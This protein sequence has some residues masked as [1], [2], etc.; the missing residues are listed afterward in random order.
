MSK[1]IL[2]L[3]DSPT[4]PTGL[5][6]IAK[7]I[8]V[9]IHETMGE[10]FKVATFGLGG[11]LS[12]NFSFP[13]YP[14][15]IGKGFEAPELPAVWK[16]FAGDERGVVLTI[17]NPSWLWWMGTPEKLPAGALKDFMLNKPFDLW[18]YFPVDGDGPTGKLP[19]TVGDTIGGF[20][21]VLTY[22]KWAA[23][24]IEK[25]CPMLAPVEHLPHMIDTRHY[26]PRDKARSRAVFIERI[27]SVSGMPPLNPEVFLVGVVATN[28]ARKDWY[29]AFETCA[30][31][32]KFGVQVGMWIHTDA[33][34][35]HWNLEELARDFGMLERVI[36]TDH[37]LS[38]DDLALAYSACDVTLGIGSGEGWGYPLSESLACGTPVVHG[39]YA[40]GAE[41]V[42][43]AGLVEPMAFRGDG[44]YA[45][46]RPVYDAREWAAKAMNFG[47]GIVRSS[48]LSPYI[49]RDNAWPKWKEWLRAGIE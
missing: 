30:E 33:Y 19:A 36:F 8:A 44:F 20:D 7:D 24:V 2:I 11:P 42:P 26:H 28:S 45:I 16:D 32:R 47:Q 14:L 27:K 46:R 13:Q 23:G 48:L 49:Y 3:S 34:K 17:W 40:G 22:T 39:N 1:P 18:G 9:G 43:K 35:K 38:D 41:F 6:R 21:R 25:T 15:M 37:V 12:R 10:E 5:G 31:L 4:A 29:L